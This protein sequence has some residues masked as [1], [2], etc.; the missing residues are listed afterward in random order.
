MA[1]SL[2][3]LARVLGQSSASEPPAARDQSLET[4]IRDE[5]IGRTISPRGG[6]LR[7]GGLDFLIAHDM[8]FIAWENEVTN[9]G[10]A[11]RRQ[12]LGGSSGLSFIR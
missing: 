10:G 4:W 11:G 8:R 12:A 2:H 9:D 3:R 1:Q 5:L 6:G 7:V